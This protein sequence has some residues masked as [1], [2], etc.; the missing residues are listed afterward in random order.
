[1]FSPASYKDN[2][3]YGEYNYWTQAND[4]KIHQG[5]VEDTLDADGNVVLGTVSVGNGWRKE[6]KQLTTPSAKSG[7]LFAPEEA[8][9]TFQ[10]PF[11]YNAATNRYEYDSKKNNLFANKD[12]GVLEY[13]SALPDGYFP[14]GEGNY[15]FGMATTLPFIYKTAVR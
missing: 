1:M 9:G 10:M 4:Y 5:L 2:S 15:W 12:T 13:A 6:E 8:V 7:K 3:R 14:L 11:R